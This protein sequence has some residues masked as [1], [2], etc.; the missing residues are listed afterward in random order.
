MA[1]TGRWIT[2]GD[3]SNRRSGLS[4]VLVQLKEGDV[5]YPK[6]DLTTASGVMGSTDV[7][8]IPKDRIAFNVRSAG[9]NS[10]A[11]LP[12]VGLYDEK[13]AWVSPPEFSGVLQDGIFTAPRAGLY[14]FVLKERVQ[15]NTIG[16]MEI[17]WKKNG[18]DTEGGFE[19]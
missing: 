9:A 18:A 17:E 11:A 5:L 4:A 19:M 12:L 13:E 2:T 6:S 1:A 8:Q 16:D 7:I 3:A 14:Y 15:D 10:S